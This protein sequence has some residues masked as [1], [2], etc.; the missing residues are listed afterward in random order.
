MAVN[1]IL[2]VDVGGTFTDFLLWQEDGSVRVYKR[3]ST[4][5]EP[6]QGVLAGL[7]EMSVQPQTV[8]H[9]ST[10]ATNALLERKGAP[11]ALITTQGFRDV[12]VIGRQAR[13]K[14]YE[15]HPRRPPPL[16][17][18]EWRLEVAERLDHQGHVLQ[19]LDRQQAESL[20]ER[21]VAG[22][23]EALAVC[24][25][26]SFL[27]P[28][29]EAAIAEF[30]RQRGLFVAASHEVLPEYREY[31][32]TATTV[33][34]AYIGPV[35]S[36]YLGRLDAGLR[37]RGVEYL[38]IMQSGGGS[39]APAAVARL[40]VHTVLS[41]PAGGVAGAFELAR[42]A[43]F[44][45]VITF[46]M[47]GTSTDVSLCPGRILTQ[48]EA[49]VGD[50]PVRVPAVDVHSVGAGGGSIARVDEG[51]ALRVGPE[52]AGADP[53]PA[54]YGRGKLPTVTDAHVLLGHLVPQQFLGGR[55]ALH[56]DRAA[57]V[58][59]RLA[60]EMGVDPVQAAVG[61]LRVAD[62]NMER[63]IRVIS[64]ERGYDPR[65]FAL[66]AYGGA[67]PLHACALADS[68]R[69]PRALVPPFPGVVSAFGMVLAPPTKDL[70]QAVL[71]SVPARPCS[72]W[73]AVAE[74]LRQELA[75]LHERG[76]REMA[77]EGFVAD[78]LTME[79]GLDVRYVGQSYELAVPVDDLSPDHFL[80]R[81]HALHRER[82]GHA[83]PDRD[84]EVVTLRLRVRSAAPSVALPKLPGGS[85]DA[86]T[87]L[88][89]RQAAWFGGR[90]RRT[91]VYSR[92]LLRAGNRIDGP[93]VIVQMDATTL[94]P[95]GWR[96][97][98]DAVGN[99]ILERR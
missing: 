3:P 50:L 60:A 19:P 31:E 11:T 8:V 49:H 52:S 33:V 70:S 27:S 9:G 82:Y 74:R 17:P 44:D 10:V 6:S 88:I 75:R 4:P 51:G 23:I 18:D 46:D 22:G 26:F 40:A 59:A 67:G 16:V 28:E 81:F 2:G 15:L 72:Q 45:Q 57:F 54:A 43:G 64:V 7:A 92:D 94:V 80:P 79:V 53:G 1:S 99:L 96:A 20:V 30:A 65:R 68:L 25:L 85:A 34:N 42:R 29:H 98:V 12:L 13:P 66:V 63:A 41:G 21:V 95:P 90:Q 14:L 93:A 5:Q 83:N 38:R 84:A 77:A 37:E 86:T 32:R 69:I 55:M 61:V 73:T 48:V 35:I 36:R 62:A 97:E 56:K 91:A 58:L 39:A 71:L 47:G 87:A 78:V 76:V 24:L 89:G